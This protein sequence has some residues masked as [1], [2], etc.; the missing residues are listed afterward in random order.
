MKKLVLILLFGGL[1]FFALNVYAHLPEKKAS[2]N[3]GP[4]VITPELQAS[5]YQ[6]GARIYNQL[7]FKCHQPN[8]MGIQG[9]F[10]PLKGSDYL[11]TATKKK[12]LEQ[13]LRGSNENLTVNGTQYFT[14]MP[15]Q[16]NNIDDAVE[17]V[18]YV[19]NA[20][21]NNYGVATAGDGKGLIEENK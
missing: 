8:G 12:L 2:E 3:R 4:V 9:V 15:G 7:C 21:G 14:P 11:K 5:K 10:P 18:N 1:T 19:L 13:V 17:V 16:V 6:K 20:W